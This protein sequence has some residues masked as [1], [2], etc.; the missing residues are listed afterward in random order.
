MFHN[1]YI[2]IYNIIFVLF[3]THFRIKEASSNPT[4]RFWFI[5]SYLSPSFVIVS[6]VY[7]MIYANYS[8]VKILWDSLVIIHTNNNIDVIFERKL[9][10]WSESC[11]LSKL[12]ASF[13]LLLA[14]WSFSFIPCNIWYNYKHSMQT[15]LQML[16]LL[17]LLCKYVSI[18]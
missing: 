14:F 5:F 4:T 16:N 10:L 6:F 12:F 15:L 7:N 13:A 9:T 17:K 18:C 11:L 2:H 3:W 1:I 8:G